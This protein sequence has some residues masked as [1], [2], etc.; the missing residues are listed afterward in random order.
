[1]ATKTKGRIAPQ[2]DEEFLTE[3]FAEQLASG[4]VSDASSSNTILPQLVSPR[5]QPARIN[6]CVWKSITLADPNA[7]G[8]QLQ[9]AHI[10]D[11]DL[12]NISLNGSLLERVE[13]LTTRLTGAICVEAQLKSVLFRECKLDFALLRMAR[14]Q[15][16][17]FERC[18]LTDADF[19]GADLSGTIF[20][21]CDLSRADL[22]QS[23]LFRADI[24]GCRLDGVRG[25]PITTDGLL[26]SPDQAALLI[27]LFGIRVEW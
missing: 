5:G 11:S 9:D 17:V 24:R 3:T 19:Y 14:L 6:R 18:N 23:K 27:T 13:I 10:E 20:R 15:Q 8:L 16:C 21:D 1:M 7:Q 2:I 12:A 26:I 4:Q 25:T 22:S